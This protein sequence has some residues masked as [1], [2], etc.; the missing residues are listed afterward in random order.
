MAFFDLPLAEL[1]EQAGRQFDPA[2]VAAFT[3]LCEV[4]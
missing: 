4:N 3:G 2:V 1:R